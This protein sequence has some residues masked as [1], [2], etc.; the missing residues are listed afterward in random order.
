MPFWD[1]ILGQS[2]GSR[3]EQAARVRAFRAADAGALAE[4]FHTAVRELGRRHYTREQVQAWSP[5]QPD[6]ARMLAKATDGRAVWVAV[7]S[8]DAP[9][10][11]IDLEPNGHIDMLFCRPEAAGRGLASALYEQ[12][13][14]A[15]RRRNIRL[16]HVEASE[17]ARPF[18]E[19]KGFVLDKRRT[20]Q[21]QG[22]LIH[23]Y[24]MVKMLT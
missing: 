5:A 22:V 7:D 14:A 13:E 21:R 16:L 2:G 24:R 18:F 12:A 15:A 20:V 6:P 11:F 4:I 23:H 19:R 9:L 3:A 10:A 17:G 1:L 8:G